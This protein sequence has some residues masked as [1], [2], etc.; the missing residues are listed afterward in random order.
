[1]EIINWLH[2]ARPALSRSELNQTV[3]HKNTGDV[4]KSAFSAMSSTTYSGKAPENCS[5][6]VKGHATQ[7]ATTRPSKGLA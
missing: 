5:A 7:V 2:Q 1:M 4:P 6:G 3:R